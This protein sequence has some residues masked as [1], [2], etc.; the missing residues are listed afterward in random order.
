MDEQSLNIPIYGG[1]S[2]VELSNPAIQIGSLKFYLNGDIFRGDELIEND[3]E[4]IKVLREYL[5]I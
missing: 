4:L 1:T 5:K 2:L 3:K